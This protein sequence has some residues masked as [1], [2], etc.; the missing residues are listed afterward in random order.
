MKNCSKRKKLLN[1]QDGSYLNSLEY[2]HWIFN[3]KFMK[4][5]VYEWL[6]LFLSFKY[7]VLYTLRNFKCRNFKFLSTVS[8]IICKT[9]L[10]RSFSNSQLQ[11]ADDSQTFL[12]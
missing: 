8:R 9:D 3:G 11:I 1:S 6:F 4:N 2:E 7:F 10:D 5:I 12:C